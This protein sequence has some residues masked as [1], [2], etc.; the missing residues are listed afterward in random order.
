[1]LRSLQF[2]CS[3]VCR[4]S[5]LVLAQKIARLLRSEINVQSP[6][7]EQGNGNEI[8]GAMF[9]L[10]VP[11]EL[12]IETDSCA[13]RE[14]HP[15]C[16]STTRQR[17]GRTAD[18]SLDGARI[19]LVEDDPLNSLL[20]RAKLESS[21]ELKGYNFAVE[22]CTSAAEAVSRVRL[23]PAHFDIILMDEHFATEAP[24]ATTTSTA[25]T[26]APSLRGSDAIRL[27]RDEIDCEALIISC[28]G[29]CLADDMAFY[30][31]AGADVCWNAAE[32][33][34]LQLDFA[35]HPTPFGE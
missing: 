30:K 6:W 3:L 14:H 8:A 34:I 26:L 5:Q 33:A 25:S 16:L 12:A 11:Y 28:S 29:N 7:R 23:R 10:R 27:L 20:M 17:H 32:L 22:H 21:E 2:T 31:N 18:L 19:L 15:A 13:S 35:H 4:R 1:M 9:F 24:C